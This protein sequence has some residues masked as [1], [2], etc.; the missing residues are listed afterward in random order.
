M[1]AQE[2][3]RFGS[4]IGFD[5]A[6]ACAGGHVCLLFYFRIALE[7][8]LPA[9][10]STSHSNCPLVGCSNCAGNCSGSYAPSSTDFSA[11]AFS[12]PATMKRIL[13]ALFAAGAVKVMRSVLSLPTQL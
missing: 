9:A 8:I 7:S 6:G 11:G 5:L 10:S 13:P 12:F 4:Q 1:E 3:F 2:R